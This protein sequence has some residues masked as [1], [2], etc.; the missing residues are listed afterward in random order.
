[1][2]H[3]CKFSFTREGLLTEAAAAIFNWCIRVFTSATWAPD[4]WKLA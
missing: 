1:M 2:L 4:R 3:G